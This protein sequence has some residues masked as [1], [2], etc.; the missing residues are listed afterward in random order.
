MPEGEYLTEAQKLLARLERSLE[1]GTRSALTVVLALAEEERRAVYLVGGSV[2]DLA[3][4]RAQVDVDLVAEGEVLMKLAQTAAAKLGARYVAHGAFGT[5]TLSGAD[6]RLDLAMTRAE[7]YSRPGAL[8]RVR[9][10]TIEE[11][12]ARRDFSINAMALALCGP[13]RGQ[14]LDPFD[15]GGDLGRGL[16]RVLHDR[17]F[18]DDATRI[19]RAVRYEARLSFHI[20]DATLALLQRDRSYL[21]T[22]SGARLRQELLHILA[23][24]EPEKALRRCQELGVLGAIHK[25]LRFDEGLAAAFQQARQEAEASAGVEVYIGL[26]GTRLSPSDA[27]AVASRLALSKR[28]RQALEGAAALAELMPWLARP[29]RRPS[30]AAQR[31]ESYPPSSRRAWALVAPEAA[32]ERLA[33]SLGSWRYVKPRL[34]GGALEELGV[35]KGP[36]MGEVLRLLR[37]ARLDGEVK[38]REDEVEMVRRVLDQGGR[39]E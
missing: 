30:Q 22:I 34:D 6:F 24:E 21:D 32:R 25:A 5:V 2:R 1:A 26:L 20:E 23:E 11:D 13:E 10:A 33:L 9:P 19:L 4:G 3:L 7:S 27:A 35:K 12:L 39:K 28:Q 17:S 36:R 15:G 18:V 37:E 8:P 16:V 29:D 31:L 38:S 14:L